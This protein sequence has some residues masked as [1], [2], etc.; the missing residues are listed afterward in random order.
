LYFVYDSTVTRKLSVSFVRF[1]HL[2]N[3]M[4]G[5]SLG[6]GPRQSHIRFAWTVLKPY[7][8]Q[9][10][11]TKRTRIYR[12]GGS[13]GSFSSILVVKKSQIVR[14]I[15]IFFSVVICSR[16]LKLTQ[17]KPGTTDTKVYLYAGGDERK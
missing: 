4:L 11:R 10:F 15:V 2:Q 17:R 8:R 14:K 5:R 7:I 6:K 13:M 3:T 12:I 9:S 16:Q 1:R